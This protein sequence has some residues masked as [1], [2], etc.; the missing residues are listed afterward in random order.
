MPKNAKAQFIAALLTVGLFV[1]A[2]SPAAAAVRIEGQV[3]GGGGPIANSTVTLWAASTNAPSQLGQVKTDANGGFEITVERSS[4]D[5]D[6]ILY[7]IATGGQPTVNKAG[8]D[9]PAI[10]LMTVV[11]SKPPAKVIINEM[12]TV[13][14]AW[15]GAQ[16]LNG[17][18]LSGKGSRRMAGLF[19][20]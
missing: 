18:A 9:N 1:W 11:G 3:Q 19:R 4:G 17:I 5:D 7:L 2:W 20:R 10:A 12:T 13:A 14:S 8:G 16:F 15:T 6:T